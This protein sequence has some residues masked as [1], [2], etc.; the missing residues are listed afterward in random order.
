MG[1]TGA[2][3]QYLV[4]ARVLTRSTD[5]DYGYYDGVPSGG[6]GTTP[7]RREGTPGLSRCTR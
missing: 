6:T 2:T 7:E 4:G 1:V 3:P 5:E